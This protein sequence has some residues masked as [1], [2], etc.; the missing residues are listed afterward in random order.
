MASISRDFMAEI[1]KKI[2][3]L[4]YDLMQNLSLVH[5]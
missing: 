2:T 1:T 3:K 5:K 4:K